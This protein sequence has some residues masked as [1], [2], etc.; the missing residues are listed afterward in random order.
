MDRFEAIVGI[1]AVAF[2]T[3]VFTGFWSLVYRP[4]C[5][6][7]ASYLFLGV[8][9]GAFLA[10]GRW[11]KFLETLGVATVLIFVLAMWLTYASPGFLLDC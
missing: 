7:L 8:L 1:A 11:H 9:A 6:M 4:Y 3:L 2:V 5:G 10:L